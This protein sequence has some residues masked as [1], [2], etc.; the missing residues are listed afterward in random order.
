MV[1]MEPGEEVVLGPATSEPPF[2]GL[3]VVTTCPAPTVLYPAPYSPPIAW[4]S[5]STGFL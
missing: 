4:R 1:V 5:K 2:S 3:N